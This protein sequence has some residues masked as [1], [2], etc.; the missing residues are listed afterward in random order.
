MKRL[1][2]VWAVG[3]AFTLGLAA[4]G[5]VACSGDDS[6]PSSPGVDSGS[7]D[8]SMSG[9]DGSVADA[10]GSTDTGPGPAADGGDA[11]CDKKPSLHAAGS[12]GPYCPFIDGGNEGANCAASQLCCLDQTSSLL[13]GSCQT[14]S[15]CPAPTAF[16]FQCS[17]PSNCNTG[18]GATTDAGDD[19]GDGG[20]AS[21]PD[22][23]P[24]MVCC[25]IGPAPSSTSGCPS[26]DL[27]S[28]L[29]STVCATSCAGLGDGGA[30][31][32]IIC[33]TATGECPA[34]M[35]CT[36]FRTHGADLGF[37]M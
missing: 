21:V 34:G 5:V 19:G 37:C 10:S 12:S 16:Y 6:N 30:A 35:T 13:N 2:M 17:G 4:L 22:A 11:G 23:G 18:S 9:Q 32:L 3:G 36:P 28:D 26:Y 33:D 8:G 29:S 25:G 1:M 27:E 14:A 31:A 24:S 7:G 20:D 15:S